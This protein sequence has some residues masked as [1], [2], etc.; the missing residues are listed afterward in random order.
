MTHDKTA[1]LRCMAA[2]LGIR[3]T[4]GLT[5]EGGRR[6]NED[7]VTTLHPTPDVAD[8]VCVEEDEDG[9]LWVADPVTPRQALLLALAMAD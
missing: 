6:V 3:Y 7:S 8:S 2:A 5:L 9:A 1:T 4:R